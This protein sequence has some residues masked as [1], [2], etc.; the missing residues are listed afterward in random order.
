M[1]ELVVNVHISITQFFLGKNIN[2]S[3]AATVVRPCSQ[4][5]VGSAQNHEETLDWFY[6][7]SDLL[8]LPY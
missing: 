1:P 4:G 2:V 8:V 6:L 7:T 3:L 5:L